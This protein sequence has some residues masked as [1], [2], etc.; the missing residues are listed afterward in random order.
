MGEGSFL[1]VGRILVKLSIILKLKCHLNSWGRKIV[2][3]PFAASFITNRI[4]SL[5]STNKCIYKIMYKF[6]EY[7]FFFERLCILQFITFFPVD[8]AVSNT[9]FSMSENLNYVG[10]ISTLP[11]L[12][13]FGCSARSVT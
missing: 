6:I 5:C 1:L 13:I 10:L 3:I 12:C 11:L 4:F 9:S 2:L 8:L 7:F